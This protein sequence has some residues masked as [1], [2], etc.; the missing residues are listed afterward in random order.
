M[1]EF[2][3]LYAKDKNGKIK[4]WRVRIQQED[5]VELIIEYGYIGGK[6]TVSTIE[7]SSGKNIGKKNETT[8]LQQGFLQAESKFNDKKNKHNFRES[9]EELYRGEDL[10]LKPMLAYDYFKHSKKVEEW[11]DIYIQPKLDGYRMIYNSKSGKC[12]SRQGIEYNILYGQTLNNELCKLKDI[13]L[14]GELYTDKLDFEELAVLK[15]KKVLKNDLNNLNMVK[16]HVYD[17]VDKTKTF[18]ERNDILKQ[19]FKEYDFEMIEYV[20]TYNIK[21]TEMLQ[22]ELRSYH[23]KFVEEKFEG[24]IIRN[25]DAEYLE[26]HRSTS[27]LKYKDFGDA[28]FEIVDYT[29]EEDVLKKSK[30]VMWKVCIKDKIY[31]DVRPKGT[32]KERELLYNKCIKDFSEYRGKKLWVKFFNYTADGNIRFPTT[33]RNTFTEYI[34]DIIM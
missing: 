15:K 34:R 8:P 32:K 19:L 14:D 16:Y 4:Q 7:I 26:N 31:C 23:D 22:K 20:D 12:T 2:P 18:R 5:K 30:L 9:I 10:V 33:M 11:N 3:V 13:I 1:R 27:L 17:I 25:G 24:A 29:Y 6:M 28:E 21:K